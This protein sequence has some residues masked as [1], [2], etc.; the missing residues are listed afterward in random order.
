MNKLIK[1]MIGLLWLMSGQAVWGQGPP[2]TTPQLEDVICSSKDWNWEVTQESSEHCA[3][4]TAISSRGAIYMNSP[5]KDGS[6]AVSNI[7]NQG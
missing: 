1:I 3:T 4:W 2:C 6:G 5:W 7:G